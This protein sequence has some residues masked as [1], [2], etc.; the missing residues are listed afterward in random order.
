MVGATEYVARIEG[1]CGEEKDVVV[2]FKYDKKEEVIDKIK[3]KAELRS[4]LAG[5]VFDMMFNDVSF[6][7]YK[8]GKAIF[9]G[10]KSR[11]ELDSLLDR[12]LL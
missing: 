12:L 11:E 3:K 4:S 10:V 2:T 6:R 8:S 1:A 9:R 7:V 5:I